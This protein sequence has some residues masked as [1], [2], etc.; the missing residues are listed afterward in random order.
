M[1]FKKYRKLIKNK[2][3]KFI[4]FFYIICGQKKRIFEKHKRI[5]KSQNMFDI[6]LQDI[7]SNFKNIYYYDISTNKNKKE[8]FKRVGIY[9]ILKTIYENSNYTL[10]FLDKNKKTQWTV[11]YYSNEIF[12]DGFTYG[13]AG[14]EICYTNKYNKCKTLRIILFDEEWYPH[15]K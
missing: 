10:S 6:E 7:F 3:I 14:L 9:D 5:S 12:Y 4:K 8:L 15:Y 1:K 2:E 11:S 13:D